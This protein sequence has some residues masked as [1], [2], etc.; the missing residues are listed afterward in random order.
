METG[1]HNPVV[2]WKKKQQQRVLIRQQSRSNVTGN[3]ALPTRRGFDR[4]RQ[5]K[6]LRFRPLL[7]TRVGVDS[8]YI[9][10]MQT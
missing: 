1:A 4:D 8:S 3:S 7:R 2:V 5:Q 10:P 9:I 6:E